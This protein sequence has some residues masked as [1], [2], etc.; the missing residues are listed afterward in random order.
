MIEPGTKG[1]A[2]RDVVDLDRA[3]ALRLLASTPLGR[4]VYTRNALP[5]IR[6][7]NHMV[8][9]GLIVIRTR[10]TSRLAGAVSGNS[11]VVV[12]YAADDIDPILRVGWSVSV[13]GLAHTVTDAERIARYEQLLRP[14]VEGVMDSVITIEPTIVSGIRLIE[15][16]PTVSDVDGPSGVIL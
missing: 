11:P 12:T 16:Q 14:W 2:P 7:V 6:P 5:A 3:E 15:R 4:V 10:L 8:D 1:A 13:T 9:R